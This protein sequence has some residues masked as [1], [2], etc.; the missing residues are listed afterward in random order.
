MYTKQNMPDMVKKMPA[1][2]QD[3]WLA[4]FNAALAEYN[5]DEARAM[6]TAMAAVQ[7]KYKHG[8]DGAWTAVKAA[9]VNSSNRACP[10]MADGQN[11]PMNAAGKCAHLGADNCCELQPS[12]ASCCMMK[13]KA[14]ACPMM[15]GGE[16]CPMSGGSCPQLADN[17]CRALQAEGKQCCMIKSMITMQAAAETLFSGRILAAGA[18]KADPDYGWRWRVQIIDAGEDKQGNAVYPL[19]VLHAAAHLYEGARVFALSEGQHAAGTHPYGNSVRDL[20]GRIQGAKPNA[21]GIEG[22]LII[23]RATA[24]QWLRDS[25]VD[26]YEQNMIGEK[27]TNDVL[28]LSHDVRGLVATQGKKQVVTKIVKVTSVD[29]V[30]EPI[31][32]GKF[33]RMAAA[34]RAASQNKEATMYKQ[35]LAALKMQ[36][37]DLKTK[38][39]ELE[40]KGDAVTADEVNALVAAAVVKPDEGTGMDAAVAKHV[41][42]IMAAA[43]NVSK[44]EAQKLLDKAMKTF[45]D[46][47]K[48][49]ACSS[50]LAEELVNSGLPEILRTSVQ[51]QFSGKVFEAAELR[52]AITAEKEIPTSSR[53]AAGRS[54]PAGCARRWARANPRGF[55]RRS[56]SS[57]ACE[58]EDEVQGRARAYLAA[59]AHTRG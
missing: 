25:L 30:Y 2:A 51:K 45:D 59:R 26:A 12:G 55:R 19:A 8:A 13:G 6:A 53:A 18:N 7:K 15:A 40:A 37:P 20:V 43:A 46:A 36:R 57:S 35:L 27:S 38:I 31:G 44:A 16:D 39:E 3:I 17:G 9:H 50:M 56:T 58:V 21:T 23:L 32:G 24:N 10:I 29:V 49:T 54:A 34:A 41:E 33:L 28:G 4:A 42:Q 47:T 48:L 14:M 1:A 5:G 52:A 11:C 22:T